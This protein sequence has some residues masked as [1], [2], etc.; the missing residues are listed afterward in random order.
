MTKI[1]QAVQTSGAVGGSFVQPVATVLSGAR[2]NSGAV[3]ASAGRVVA[4]SKTEGTV[5]VRTTTSTSAAVKAAK[6]A[7]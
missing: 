4:T 1:D 5:T 3:S 7:G 2:S 6:T